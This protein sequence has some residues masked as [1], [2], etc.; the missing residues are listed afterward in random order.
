M[1]A[2]D[3]GMHD[4]TPQVSNRGFKHYEAIKASQADVRVY[5]SSAAST[6]HL[7]LSVTGDALLAVGTSYGASPGSV[8]AHLTLEQAAAVRDVLDAAI[9]GALPARAMS[10]PCVIDRASYLAGYAA[11]LTDL[12]G[13]LSMERARIMYA[14]MEHAGSQS[15]DAAGYDWLDPL[16]V[17]RPTV[18]ERASDAVTA[19]RQGRE[20]SIY[21]LADGV[22]RVKIGWT[23]DDVQ[24]RASAVSMA[25]GCELVIAAQFRGTVAEERQIHAR[26]ADARIR[27]EWFHRTPAVVAWIDSLS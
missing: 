1:S 18:A 25:S 13:A 3:H 4:C 7:W 10:A 27:G 6:P 24:R 19:H 11:A 5:E 16:L 21:V 26:F 22:A 20:G 9:A 15:Y 14:D 23:G 8:G 17:D 12:N 2:Q